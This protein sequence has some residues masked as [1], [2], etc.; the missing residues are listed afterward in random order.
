[1]MTENEL[2]R[3]LE[4]TASLGSV[5]GME[6]ITR[7]CEILG[8]PQDYGKIIHIAG[9]N[10]KG[11]TGTLLEQAL[12]AMGYKVGRY[13]SPAVFYDEEIIKVQN[14]PI[15]KAELARIMTEV[16]EACDCM[17]LK[18]YHHP[19][20]FEVETAAAF[21]YF[22]EK[23]CD[24]TLMEVGMG[25]ESDAT[26][27]IKEPLISVITSISMDHM[28][29]LG[30]TIEEIAAKKAGIIKEGCPC[31][32]L[33]QERSVNQVIKNHGKGKDLLYFAD[34]LDYPIKGMTLESLTLND[35]EYGDFTL[36]M[37]GSFQRENFA[38]AMTTLKVLQKT[39]ELSLDEHIDKIKEA[40][41]HTVWS[42]RFECICRKPLCIIDGCHNPGAA[43]ELSKTLKNLFEGYHIHFVIGVLKDKDYHGIFSRVLPL[44]EDAFCVTPKSARGMNATQL[45]TV[46]NDYLQEVTACDSC[47]EAV[48]LAMKKCKGA[49][50]MVLAFGSLSYLGEVKAYVNGICEQTD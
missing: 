13:T 4:K 23:Q 14:K 12:M 50:H 38:V 37:T 43:K 42:G 39:G 44:G 17:V 7:L 21:L 47:E 29:F 41:R 6:T 10:G 15:E 11:S 28:Q 27:V 2:R 45:K 3:F 1:M 34:S 48:D 22:K 31:V 5:L 36:H 25:G 20:E 35:K 32:A 8:N 9:T 24:Y 46:A 18:G 30:D 33:K 40:W 19:T 49:N 26:N 16:K